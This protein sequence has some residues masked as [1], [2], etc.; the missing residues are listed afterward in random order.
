MEHETALGGGRSTAGVV[1][2]GDTV[3]RPVR[4]RAAFVHDLLRHL[5]SRKFDS[6]PRFLGIDGAGRE[7]LSFIP[8]EVPQELGGFSDD[9]VAAA[10]RLLRQLHDATVDSRLRDGREIVRH[11]DAGPCNCV[12]VDGMPV[13]F[14]DFDT[15]HAGSR[16]EDVAY[17]AWFWTDI[18]N[19]ELPADEQGRRVADFFRHY[20][21][22]SAGAI[23]AIILAQTAL[24]ER[25]D[26]AGVRTW[27]NA[28]RVWVESKRDALRRR[29]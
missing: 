3:R 21:L 22:D 20:G 15:A 7:M 14:I 9:Q 28:C 1:R 25:T 24:A 11:G 10:A 5:E 13:A 27:A 26:S 6:A 2:I 12:F 8:G 18:G 23:E 4:A 19:D 16:V 29:T 17:A